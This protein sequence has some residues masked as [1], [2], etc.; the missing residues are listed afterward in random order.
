M[1]IKVESQLSSFNRIFEI[2]V[3]SEEHENVVEKYEYMI[4]NY[5][6]QKENQNLSAEIAVVLFETLINK[7]A[8][9][10]NIKLAY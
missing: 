6:F 4:R 5:W 7:N 3:N 10:H 1:Y 2:S 8:V 9:L